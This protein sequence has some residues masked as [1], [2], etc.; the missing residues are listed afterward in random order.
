[1]ASNENKNPGIVVQNLTKVNGLFV[2]FN[3]HFLVLCS[4]GTTTDATPGLFVYS[5]YRWLH[6]AAGVGA[7]NFQLKSCGVGA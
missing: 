1:M 3:T 2:D 5:L 4:Y 7:R 6:R